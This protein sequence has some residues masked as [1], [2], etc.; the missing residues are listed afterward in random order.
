MRGL[1]EPKIAAL[2][3]ARKAPQS[4]LVKNIKKQCDTCGADLWVSIRIVRDCL[5]WKSGRFNCYP[6]HL[7]SKKE[8]EQAIA[9]MNKR[10][11]KK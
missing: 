1:G 5:K 8:V 11:A 9:A 6:C 3:Q 10:R 2:A 7:E 4:D